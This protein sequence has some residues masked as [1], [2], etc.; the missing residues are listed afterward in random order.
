ILRDPLADKVKVLGL[1]GAVH[2]E[3]W[4]GK[5][6]LKSMYSAA[7]FI[8]LPS[9]GEGWPKVISEAMSFGVIPIVSDVSGIKQVL[10]QMR[11]GT[12]VPTFQPRDYADAIASYLIDLGRY[13]TESLAA[14]EAAAAFTFEAWISNLSR[15]FES[16]WG[17]R[18]R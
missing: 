17:E 10:S 2:F 6:Q 4:K 8:L 14:F 18:Y 7:H 15:L 1:T 11:V 12:V 3:G 5:E 13:R 16:H 9:Q